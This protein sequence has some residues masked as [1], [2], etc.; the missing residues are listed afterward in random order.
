MVI[1]VILI[2]FAMLVACGNDSSEKTN[3]N[4][5]SKKET[6][7]SGSEAP[8]SI[9]ML[10][11]VWGQ[12]PVDINNSP[13]FTK[14]EEATNTELD[15]QLV[16]VSNYDQNFSL[17]LSAN[18]LP[19]VVHAFSSKSPVLIDAINQG[20]FHN[21]GDFDLEKYENLNTIPEFIWENA[22]INGEIYGVPNAVG[23]NSLSLSLRQ[24]WLDQLNLEVPTTL[25]ELKE[26]LIAFSQND[27]DNNGKKDTFGLAGSGYGSPGSVPSFENYL[28]GAFGVREPVFEDDKL[29]L[30]WMTEGYKEYLEYMQ[31][32]YANEVLPKEYYLMGNSDV[33]ELVEQNLVGSIGGTIHGAG[34]KTQV[35]QRQ[36]PDA[37]F[38]VI[39]PI[40]GPGG[41]AGSIQPGYY[42]MWLIPKSVDEEKVPKI[43]EYLD[44]TATTEINNLVNFGIEGVHYDELDDTTVVRS[45]EQEALLGEDAG[46]GAIVLVNTYNAYNDV[47]KNRFPKEMEGALITRIDEYN[48]VAPSDP[49]RLLI[50]ETHSERSADV[51]GQL[52][53]MMIQVITGSAD[54][55]KWSEYVAS[56]K[57]NATVQQMMTEY[58]EQYEMVYGE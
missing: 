19:D 50:S 33:D 36:N 25:D 22:S 55:D 7:G 20:A 28:I 49:F 58:A 42:G 44:K 35:L 10:T 47:T 6:E 14:L 53:E 46:Q 1:L 51:F 39:P 41:H 43:L 31:D 27:P 8:T 21:L 54:L 2:S 32:L 38:T 24:D 23:L 34:E 29:L 13:I 57:E 17:V 40:E 37:S 3:G 15:I 52:N 18:Q 48:E 16:P 26:V 12:P 5:D 56:M 9:S 11:G 4:T 45:E 30:P